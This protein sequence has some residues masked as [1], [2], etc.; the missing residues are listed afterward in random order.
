MK[1]VVI[2]GAP[3]AGKDEFVKQV[4]SIIDFRCLN[5]ST[6]D[7]VK[8]VAQFCGWNGEKTPRNRKFLSDLKDLLTE[9]DDIPLKKVKDTIEFYKRFMRHQNISEDSLIVFIHVR[10]PK[11]IARLAKEWGAITLFIQRPNND[12]AISNHADLEV[13][14]YQYDYY[15]NND[16][17][18]EDLKEKAKNF[19]Q[20]LDLI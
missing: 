16:G 10:E 3:S 4:K 18:I 1:T 15:I 11:E 8:E 5:V 7:F 14:N 6:V 2:N 9:W 13:A 20:E 12:Q 17:T 19:L